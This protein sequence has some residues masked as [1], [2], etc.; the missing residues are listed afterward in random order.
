MTFDER[1]LKETGKKLV[2]NAPKEDMGVLVWANSEGYILL[3]RTPSGA[4]TYSEEQ[5]KV[6]YMWK[7]KVK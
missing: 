3:T 7:E 5:L 2:L 1:Y 4:L 6:A